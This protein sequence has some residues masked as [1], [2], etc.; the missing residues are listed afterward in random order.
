MKAR[1]KAMNIGIT[2]HQKLKDSSL[3]SW[4]DIKFDELLSQNTQSLVGLS[5][6]A[7]GADQLFAKSVLKNGGSL[8]AII[9]FEDYEL[10]FS[11]GT[12]REGYIRLLSKASQIEVLE[13]KES[14]EISYFN[15]G[16]KLVDLSDVLFAVW[17]G[18][19]AA[20]LGGTGDVVEYAIQTNKK[21][22][23]LNPIIQNVIEK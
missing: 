18:K 17:D 1:I 15:A 5:S 12:H 21:I 2:G 9:P 4:V 8:Y 11:E 23:H 3:W 13:R 22:F 20:G 14:D 10:K 7:I 19:P 6:L 16:K